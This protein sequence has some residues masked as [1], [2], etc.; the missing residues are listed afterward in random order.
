M[1]ILNMNLC[2]R[3]EIY[4][5]TQ[6]Y[7]LKGKSAIT[8]EIDMIGLQNLVWPKNTHNYVICASL[9][10]IECAKVKI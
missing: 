5:Q 7:I 8:P 9:K 3:T 1:Q 2:L 10:Q 4:V 6:G